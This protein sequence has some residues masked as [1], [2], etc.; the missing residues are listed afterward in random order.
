MSRVEAR[1][2][3]AAPLPGPTGGLR[4]F[5]FPVLNLRPDPMLGSAEEASTPG[6]RGQQNDG[7]C[8]KYNQVPM[9]KRTAVGDSLRQ[10]VIVAVAVFGRSDFEGSREAI[11]T[12]PAIDAGVRFMGRPH[13]R[14]KGY[15]Y[16][17]GLSGPGSQSGR[18]CG[19]VAKTVLPCTGAFATPQSNFAAATS[20]S[21]RSSPFS[22]WS[23]WPPLSSPP[24][25]WQQPSWLQPFS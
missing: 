24:P 16:S 6:E 23:A 17:Q 1:S 13:L 15:A 11:R 5:P 12:S 22:G 2:G 19:E 14:S 9:R 3:A 25:S 21:P 10:G 7:E 20:S 8:Q 4:V 18:C